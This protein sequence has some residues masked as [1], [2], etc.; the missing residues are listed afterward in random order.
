[1]AGR[2]T[3]MMEDRQARSQARF[4]VAYSK[5]G[6][7]AAACKA[8]GI[9]YTTV[10]N[11]I[12]SSPEFAFAFDEAKQIAVEGLENEAWRRAQDGV[13]RTKGVYY[14]GELVGKEVHTDY[15]DTLMIFLLKALAPSKYREVVRNE[16]TGPDGKDIT[17][18]VIYEEGGSAATD[19]TSA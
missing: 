18:K 3:E 8:S 13:K 9:S 5:R 7:K 4:L 15:S 2:D 6:N 11:W 17:I 10:N 16:L 12:R 1:M 19:A 14:E